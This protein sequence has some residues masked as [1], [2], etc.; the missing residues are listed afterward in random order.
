[1]AAYRYSEY[2]EQIKSDAFNTVYNPGTATPFS[3]IYRCLGCN[4]EAVSEENK[5]LPPQNH[6]TH[7]TAQGDIRWRMT[8]FADH[9]P[10]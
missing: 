10:K 4:R 9:K 1:M 3:G 6:H 7:T 8:V 2:L 5:P